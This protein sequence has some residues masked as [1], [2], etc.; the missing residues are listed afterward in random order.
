MVAGTAMRGGGAS[1]GGR[2]G[3]TAEGGQGLS[4]RPVRA[5]V[6]GVAVRS[7]GHRWTSPAA[8]ATVPRRSDDAGGLETIYQSL[9]VQ[10][11]G[12]LRKEL[13]SCLRTGRAIRKN[14]SRIIS[15]RKIPDMV[16]IS[17]RPAEIETGPCP[18]TGKAT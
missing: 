11:R 8:C 15:G 7:C 10:G 17:D 14:R 18:A 16:M 2:S 5:Q 9:F 3:S 4:L 12:A 1:S 6:V 13:A